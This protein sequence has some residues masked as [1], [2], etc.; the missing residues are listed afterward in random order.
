MVCNDG[1]SVGT[2]MKEVQYS[3]IHFLVNEGNKPIEICHCMK[4]QHCKVCLYLQQVYEL[5]RK[6]KNA[7]SSVTPL[8]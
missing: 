2:F 6:F 1:R 8:D 5:S 4:L 7:M 3:V